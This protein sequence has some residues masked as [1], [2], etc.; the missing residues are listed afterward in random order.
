MA[1]TGGYDATLNFQS[2]SDNVENIMYFD[3]L[4]A[5]ALLGARRGLDKFAKKI[6]KVTQDGIKNP[7]KTGIRYPSFRVRSSRAGDYP[8]NQT[9]R[10]RRSIGYQLVGNQR[11][12]VGSSVYYSNYLAF[13]TR[14]MGKRAFIGTAIKNNLQVGYDMISQEINKSIM[15]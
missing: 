8:A 15:L 3:M 7:P 13:G 9:G 11:A 4:S 1:M 6:R 2:F 10:L 5:W 14:Y 12:F